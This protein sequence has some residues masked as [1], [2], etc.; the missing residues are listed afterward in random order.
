MEGGGGSCAVDGGGGDAGR[1]L[2]DK[3]HFAPNSLKKDLLTKI[4]T[5]DSCIFFCLVLD[6]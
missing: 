2:T 3:D 4:L 5:F 6:F 1:F